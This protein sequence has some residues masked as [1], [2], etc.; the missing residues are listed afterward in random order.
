MM[1]TVTPA[2]DLPAPIKR[3]FEAV[4]NF[5]TDTITTTPT[6]ST[7]SWLDRCLDCGVDTRPGEPGREG[8]EGQCEW[9]AVWDYL[10]QEAG[11]QAENEM[12][13]SS[14]FLCI[15]C[16]EQRLGREL[17]AEDFP[18]YP[19]NHQQFGEGGQEAS[20]RPTLTPPGDL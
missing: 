10:W 7:N 17:T 18:D 13:W 20:G 9:Y 14:G 15:G 6:H 8:L 16:L 2:V 19:I 11:M 12:L 1:R 4:V 5:M 3:R